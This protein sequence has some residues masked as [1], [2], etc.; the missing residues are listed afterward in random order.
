[1]KRIISLLLTVI[2]VSGIVCTTAV[3]VENTPHRTYHYVALGDSIAAGFGLENENGS[4]L[5]DPA[6]ILTEELLAHPI[7]GAY[8]QLFGDRV[9]EWGQENGWDVSTSNLACCAYRACDV[10]QTILN[11]GYV[12]PIANRLFTAFGGARSENPLEKYHELYL[13]CLQDADLVSIQLGGNDLIMGAIEPMIKGDNP[14]VEAVGMVMT[15][16]FVGADTETALGMG[17]GIINNNRDKITSETYAEAI[18]FFATFFRRAEAFVDVAAD[19]V[20]KV[21]DA[22]RSVKADADIAVL[23][24][25]NPYG[26]S[27]EYNGKV[28]SLSTVLTDIFVRSRNYMNGGDV[29]PERSVRLALLRALVQKELAYPLQYLMA[30]RPINSLITSLNAKL[31]AVAEQAG[32][33]FIDVYDISN[34]QNLDPHPDAARQREIAE[35]MEEALYPTVIS[36]MT[37]PLPILGDVDGDGEITVLDATFIMRWSAGLSLPFELDEAL[38]DVDGDGEVTIPD[39]TIIQRFLSGVD[40]PH[41]LGI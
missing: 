18:S 7:R 26:N 20:S 33:T 9:A 4:F 21:I 41:G 13:R 14:I 34:E 16:I 22:V 39:A 31:E 8:P 1:M 35:R 27:L 24:L 2:L 32:V 37:A 23:S 10:E 15:M 11:E 17:M 36:R 38:G 12:G 29:A 6:L 3:A 19:N 25:F 40:D 30:G 5:G 28:Q